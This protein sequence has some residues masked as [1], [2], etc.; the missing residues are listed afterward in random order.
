M[1]DVTCPFSPDLGRTKPLSGGDTLSQVLSSL[2]VM[3][4][5]EAYEWHNH[6]D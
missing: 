1:G 2:H 3:A 6:V 4:E 5:W